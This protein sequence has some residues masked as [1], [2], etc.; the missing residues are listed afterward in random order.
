MIILNL[1][2]ICRNRKCAQKWI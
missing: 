2:L 1:W